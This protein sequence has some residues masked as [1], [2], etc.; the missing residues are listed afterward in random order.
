MVFCSCRCAR[1]A[2]ATSSAVQGSV[3]FAPTFRKSD[4]CGASARL[5]AAV[6]LYA[7]DLLADEPY[8]EW[9]LRERERVRA[10]A[11]DALRAL[12]ELRRDE[13]A[14]AAAHLDRL[15]EMEPFDDDVQRQL[16]SAWLRLGRKSRAARHYESFRIRLAREFGQRPAFE[17]SNLP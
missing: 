9:A 8:A 11:C 12:S 10:L 4:P 7:D 6:A 5:E 1:A 2:C 14:A 3:G 16:I 13:P 17:L 15:A